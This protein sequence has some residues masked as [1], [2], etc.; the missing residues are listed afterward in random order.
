[1]SDLQLYMSVKAGSD[2]SIDGLELQSWSLT[3]S[4]ITAAE[5]QQVAASEAGEVTTLHLEPEGTVRISRFA[6]QHCLL[7]DFDVFGP[8]WEATIAA[9]RGI[10]R[11]W[12]DSDVDIIIGEAHPD[13]NN[14][15]TSENLLASGRL[16]A[17]Q[18]PPPRPVVVP[19]PARLSR[20]DHPDQMELPLFV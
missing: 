7:V 3:K 16:Y 14:M 9:V 4:I 17:P 19:P 12:R 8:D 11:S 5:A 2:P 1:M 13:T 15:V 20:R 6:R 10:Q 18:L